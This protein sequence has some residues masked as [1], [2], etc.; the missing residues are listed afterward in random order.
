[1]AATNPKGISPIR[2]GSVRLIDR[3][4]RP[5]DLHGA[6]PSDA[7]SLEV[8]LDLARCGEVVTFSSTMIEGVA[9]DANRIINLSRPALDLARLEV[10]GAG[11]LFSIKREAIAAKRLTGR[12]IA[13]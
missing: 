5:I 8:P 3:G 9:I 10:R 7:V 2:S 6:L 4:N 13:N 12:P 1:M 11:A